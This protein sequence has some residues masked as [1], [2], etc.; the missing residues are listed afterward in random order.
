[1]NA[2]LLES[3]ALIAAPQVDLVSGFS[4][5]T[6]LPPHQ[7]VSFSGMALAWDLISMLGT[8]ANCKALPLRWEKEWHG[9]PFTY[10][11]RWKPGWLA[12]ARLLS[13]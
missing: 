6:C 10:K 1:M 11:W 7:T 2:P 4:G 5:I 8:R 12:W 9:T 3:K 13:G